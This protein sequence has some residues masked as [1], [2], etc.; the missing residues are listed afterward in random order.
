MSILDIK[1]SSCHQTN[2]RKYGWINPT[3]FKNPSAAFLTSTFYCAFCSRGNA[4]KIR[5]TPEERLEIEEELDFKT[6]IKD[7][8]M[9]FY[10]GG[11]SAEEQQ[12]SPE[13]LSESDALSLLNDTDD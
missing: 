6:L 1:C 12:A 3:Q 11:P 13:V 5:F 7:D 9:P 2:T 4:V 8:P 10:I